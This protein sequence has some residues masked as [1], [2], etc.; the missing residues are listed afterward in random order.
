MKPMTRR[1]FMIS[2]TFMA[3]GTFI[4]TVNA[5]GADIE[6]EESDCGGSGKKILV[7]YASLCGSTGQVAKEIGDVFC[8]RSAQVDI[9]YIDHVTDIS[10][11]DGIVIGSAVKSSAW[12]ENAIAFVTAHQNALTRIPVIYFLTCLALYKESEQGYQ[13]AMRYFN[14]VLKAVPKVIPRTMQPFGGTL[15]YSKLNFMYRMV[16]KSKMA[17]KGIPEGDFRNFDLI[18]QWAGEKALPLL[19]T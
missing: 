17:K 15:D 8:R 1:K 10:Q 5:L 12:H 2:G 3:A 16:M 18:R 14:P 19:M 7:A 4:P 6:F 9:R 13:T 11:Y